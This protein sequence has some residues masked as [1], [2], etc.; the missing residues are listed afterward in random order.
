MTDGLPEDEIEAEIVLGPS[1]EYPWATST[2]QMLRTFVFQTLAESSHIP[3]EAIIQMQQ[4]VDYI[5]DGVIPEKDA[6]KANLK[7]IKVNE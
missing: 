6:K 4:Y 3:R 7:Q 5:N 1:D 2:I